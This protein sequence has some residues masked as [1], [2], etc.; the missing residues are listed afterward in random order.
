MGRS[1]YRI[2]ILGILALL[3]AVGGQC[4][5]AQP[6]EG[7]LPEDT[8][9]HL[10]LRNFLDTKRNKV[11]DEVDV[12]LLEP[13]KLGETVIIPKGTM[14]AGTLKKVQKGRLL[15]QRGVIR[16][17][18][19][20]YF[21][22]NGYLVKLGGEEIKFSGDMNYTSMAAGVAVP[23]AGLGFKG[24]QVNCQPGMKFKYKLVHDSVVERY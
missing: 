5:A 9:L 10:E 23:F 2:V 7:V 15:S 14:L 13:V 22:P 19:R 1:C 16:M 20:D 8:V 12:M 4:L 3:L 6:E 21:L 18:L 11:G 17:Q 24:K